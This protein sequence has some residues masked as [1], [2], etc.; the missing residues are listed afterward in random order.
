[1]NPKES[2]TVFVSVTPDSSTRALQIDKG[3]SDDEAFRQFIIENVEETARTPGLYAD[4]WNFRYDFPCYDTLHEPSTLPGDLDYFRDVIT[5]SGLHPTHVIPTLDAMYC[6]QNGIDPLSPEAEH[7]KLMTAPGYR[8]LGHQFRRY[9]DSEVS[10]PVYRAVDTSHGVLLY[11]LSGVAGKEAYQIFLQRCADQYFNKDFD[12]DRMQFYD[13]QT[14]HNPMELDKHFPSLNFNFELRYNNFTFTNMFC[15]DMLPFEILKEGVKVKEYDM[16][17][18]SECYTSFVVG[19]KLQ[20]HPN[21]ESFTIGLLNHISEHGFPTERLS[22]EWKFIFPFLKSFQDIRDKIE[23]CSDS[24]ALKEIQNDAQMRAK[25]IM[26]DCYPNR[27]SL[28]S[29]SLYPDY[30]MYPNTRKLGL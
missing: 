3:K 9:N 29:L 11:D 12:V 22:S 19:E 6:V 10:F 8:M 13:I 4:S 27:R 21:T 25:M 20:V 7:S 23:T 24:A 18:T 5:L 2:A 28:Y 15:S 16:S 14:W 30:E 17:P 26:E 1:M